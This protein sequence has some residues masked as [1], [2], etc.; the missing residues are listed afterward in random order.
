[1]SSSMAISP[2]ILTELFIEFD[3]F[4]P[5]ENTIPIDGDGLISAFR[6]QDVHVDFKI[7]YVETESYR[8]ERRSRETLFGPYKNPRSHHPCVKAAVDSAWSAN[9]IRWADKLAVLE[10]AANTY[11]ADPDTLATIKYV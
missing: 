4:T 10:E 11:Q 2:S 9:V 8:L 3:R 7:K 6:T 5:N 1:M